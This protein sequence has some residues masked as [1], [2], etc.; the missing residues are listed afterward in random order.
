MSTRSFVPKSELFD[1]IR[2]SVRRRENV[3]LRIVTEPQ[4]DTITLRLSTGRLVYVKCEDHGPLDALVLLAECEQVAFSYSS[5][6]ESDRPE[7]MSSDAFLKWLDASDEAPA[8]EAGTGGAP[9]SPPASPPPAAAVGTAPAPAPAGEGDDERWSGTLRGGQPGRKGGTAVVLVAVAAAAAIAAGGWFYLTDADPAGDT[10]ETRAPV[11]TR[12]APVRG[13][14]AGGDVV[15]ESIA[16]TTIWPAGTTHRL[17]G[18]VFVEGRARLVIE[19][20]VTVVGGPGAALIVTRDASIQARGTVRE[21]IVFTSAKPVGQRASGDW[22]GVVLL[23]NAPINRGEA[24]VEGVPR[25][26]PRSAFG[27]GQ[28]SSNC[29]VLEYVRIEFAGYPIG[30][31]GE[32]NGLTLAGCGGATLVDHVQVHRSRYDGVAILGGTVDLKYALVSYAGDDALD[33]DMGWT[34]RA[35]FLIVQQHPETGDT[36]FEGDNSADDPQAEPVS[37]PRIYNV[38]MVGSRNPGRDQRAMV[39]RHGSG[40]EFRNFLITGFPLESIDLRGELTAERIASRVLSFGSIAMSTIG[41]DGRT[42]FEDESGAGDDDGGFDEWRY[43]SELAPDV[44]LGAPEAL[45]ASAW[46]AAEPDFT[47]VAAYVGAGSQSSSPLNEEFWDSTGSYYGAVRYGERESWTR[48]W[49][50]W[51]E[52]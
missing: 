21:P 14:E 31:G 22:G 8:A 51:P 19:P 24:H 40:G 6:R 25:G 36:G 41:P 9:V 13:G 11:T 35:Q 5:V 30:A 38:T 4:R 16:E 32:L 29:G 52:R 45:G 42:Y 1:W 2:S 28:R 7:L 47:P 50:A 12:K 46:N 33:W 27:G 3:A 39:I 26:D 34:G 17:E 23:G 20:G 10:A 43:F 48:G 15:P 49:T 18:L 44:K 37:R